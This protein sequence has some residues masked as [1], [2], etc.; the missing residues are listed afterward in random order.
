MRRV[1][2]VLA[3]LV[4]LLVV[5]DRAAAHLAAGAVADAVR[6]DQR[7]SSTPSV[8]I[9][10][11]P[12]LTQALGGVYDEVDVRLADV[13]VRG[14]VAVDRV[15]VRLRGVHLPAGDAVRGAVSRVPVDDADARATVSFAALAARL[16]RPVTLGPGPAPGVLSVAGDIPVDGGAGGGTLPVRAQVRLSVAGGVLTVAP[17]R[18]SLAD[19]PASVRPRVER[20]LSQLSVRLPT[21]PFGFR[22]TALTVGADGLTVTAAGRSIVVGR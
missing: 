21:L 9:Q 7:L 14:G 18:A 3:V 19:V 4:V 20:L 15:E 11:F 8:D 12:F 22:V 13:P 2:V 5:A 6:R 17:V 16:D 1:L 10:G